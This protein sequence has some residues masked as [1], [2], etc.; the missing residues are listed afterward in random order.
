MSIEFRGLIAAVTAALVCLGGAFGLS[1]IVR[2]TQHEPPAPPVSQV[3]GTNTPLPPSVMPGPQASLVTLGQGFYA[4]S[5]AS[6]HGAQGQGN[7]GPSLQNTDQSD[8]EITQKVK[9]G[10]GG[11]M[12]AFGSK[13]SDHDIQA[14]T[15]YVHTLK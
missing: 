15:A 6:C 5:C 1:A 3:S 8:A 14:I 7:I 11:A 13:Y 12:P 9:Y 10:V 4:Q 2:A